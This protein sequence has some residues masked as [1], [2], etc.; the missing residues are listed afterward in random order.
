MGT[1]NDA[2]FDPSEYRMIDIGYTVVPGEN[3]DRPFA[4]QKGILA[5]GSYKY[6]ILDT[7]SH[8]GSHVE[9][10]GHYFGQEAGTPI[11]DLPLSRFYGP[12][13]LLSV[14]EFE[15]TADTLTNSI[16]DTIEPRDYVVARNDTEV[17]LRK[18]DA[19][20]TDDAPAFTPEAADW[21]REK[22]I[23]GVIL[24]DIGLGRTVEDS[25]EFHEILMQDEVVFVEFVDNLHEISTDR[26]TVLTLPYKV[27][28]LGSS[29][30][31]PVIIE[32]R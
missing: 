23:K 12:G 6:D 22:E 9:A 4:I 27:E 2:L 13:V 5:D 18:E 24:G 8:V 14:T 3:P 1:S 15:I 25:N 16:G 32:K 29:F 31:R 26:F 11:V 17:N 21:S 19:Y 7:H 10:S 20:L 30:C 28:R